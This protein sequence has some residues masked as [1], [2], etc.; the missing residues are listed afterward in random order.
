[1]GD[2]ERQVER[3][4]AIEAIRHL[5]AR[6]CLA[7]DGHDWAGYRSLFTDDAR[8]VGDLPVEGAVEAPSYGADEW[9]SAVA[10]TLLMKS[11]HTLHQSMIEISGPTSARG[12]WAYTQRGFGQTGGYYVEEYRK[13][14]DDWKIS[15]MRIVAIHPHDESQ[16]HSG[17]GSWEQVCESWRSLSTHVQRQVG[18]RKSNHERR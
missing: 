9:T 13:E 10:R 1:L 16:P 7:C 8:I 15:A 4:V 14:A 17:P 5:K 11:F 2:T 3:L 6:Y 18:S 12:L